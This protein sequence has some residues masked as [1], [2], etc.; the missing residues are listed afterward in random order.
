MAPNIIRGNEMFWFCWHKDDSI[1]QEIIELLEL[2]D[3]Y[4]D[5]NHMCDGN[6]LRTVTFYYGASV[7]FIFIDRISFIYQSRE[8][9]VLIKTF[10]TKLYYKNRIPK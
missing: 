4:I 8:V 1:N 9:H 6:N 3:V 7:G 2:T 10:L 5:Y